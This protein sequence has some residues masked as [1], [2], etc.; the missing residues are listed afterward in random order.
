M[1]TRCRALSSAVEAHKGGRQ[2][3][4]TVIFCDPKPSAG[5]AME[6]R[7]RV[8]FLNHG[9]RQISGVGRC[10]ANVTVREKWLGSHAAVRAPN[11]D[12]V[13][14]YTTRAHAQR[15]VWAGC[16]TPTHSHPHWQVAAAST[17]HR[18]G[19]GGRDRFPR[20]RTS[21]R[22]SPLT[23]TPAAVT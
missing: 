3:G 1:L 19:Q 18:Q 22:G 8:E 5:T 17:Q 23:A 7:T 15:P 16:L 12:L 20:P 13:A 10:Q 11:P 2:A 21:S 14:A 6:L 9:S 4:A